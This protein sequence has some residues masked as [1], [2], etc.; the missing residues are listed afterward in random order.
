MGHHLSDSESLL[1]KAKADLEKHWMFAGA[2]WNDK[3]REN[4]EKEHLEEL[5]LAVTN[6]QHGMRNIDQLLRKVMRDC[7]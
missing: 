4:F 2:A 1:K 6:A 3:A 5:H 7:S